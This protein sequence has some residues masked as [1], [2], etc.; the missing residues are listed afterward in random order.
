[1]AN[2]LVKYFLSRIVSSL[3]MMLLFR[4][5]DH[6]EISS[7]YGHYKPEFLNVFQKIQGV[8]IRF[9]S[10]FY[11]FGF[12]TKLRIIG[13][14]VYGAKLEAATQTFRDHFISRRSTAPIIECQL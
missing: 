9:V 8:F 3:V 12:C 4:Q 10:D 7:I 5:N 6:V 11:W 2:H 14:C 13:H 1:M